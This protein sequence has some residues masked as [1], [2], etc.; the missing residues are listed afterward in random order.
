MEITPDQCLVFSFCS[1][2][3][4]LAFLK[5]YKLRYK[6]RGQYYTSLTFSQISQFC[7]GF[8]F[9]QSERTQITKF[10]TVKSRYLQ[11]STCTLLDFRLEHKLA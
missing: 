8:R 7:V 1:R 10:D 5:I 6:Y 11:S 9:S 3:Y 4:S 2:T